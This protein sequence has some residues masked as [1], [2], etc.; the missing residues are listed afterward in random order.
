MIGLSWTVTSQLTWIKINVHSS[1]ITLMHCDVQLATHIYIY[2][3]I[4]K[5]LAVTHRM[6]VYSCLGSVNMALNFEKA[7][8]TNITMW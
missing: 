5:L 4:V 7:N 2:I 1:I 8:S 3:I 6:L